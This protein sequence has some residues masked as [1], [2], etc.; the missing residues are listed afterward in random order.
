MNE[1]K[2]LECGTVTAREEAFYDLSLDIEQNC[3]LTAC[4]RNFR[5]GARGARPACPGV[6][7]HTAA[8]PRLLGCHALRRVWVRCA[9]VSVSAC[10]VACGVPQ[11]R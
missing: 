1:T 7:A 3:S 10:L 6:A 11:R 2:C 5:R 4:L 9:M 8:D